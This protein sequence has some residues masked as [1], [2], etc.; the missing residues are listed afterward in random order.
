MDFLFKAGGPVG[1]RSS[2]YKGLRRRCVLSDS[3][4]G[5]IMHDQVGTECWRVGFQRKNP[6]CV[7]FCVAHQ[8]HQA[9]A[10]D[11]PVAGMICPNDLHRSAV[12]H[13]WASG[14]PCSLRISTALWSPQWKVLSSA[15]ACASAES[16]ISE[17]TS[18]SAL[19]RNRRPSTWWQPR[20]RRTGWIAFR[21]P[22]SFGPENAPAH[23]CCQTL[24]PPA[25]YCPED[26]E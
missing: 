6:A 3:I 15:I 1:H 8:T 10:L 24:S 5:L 22:N 12:R 11:N 26:P 4:Y 19:M 7:L 21:S 17:P 2:I 14:R 23:R 18:S 9:G 13:C 25:R 16:C 20:G